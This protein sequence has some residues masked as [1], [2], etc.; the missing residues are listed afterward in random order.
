MLNVGVM[1]VTPARLEARALNALVA[2]VS[3]VASGCPIMVGVTA[4]SAAASAAALSCTRFC[5][6]LAKSSAIPVKKKHGMVDN[7]KIIA[8]L[9]LRS[10][11]NRRMKS[12]R[13]SSPEIGK[14][15]IV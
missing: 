12:Q 5:V 13:M 6:A 14:L 3:A 9:P 11:V 1:L 4:A 15:Q 7:A 8:T 2:A 10:R